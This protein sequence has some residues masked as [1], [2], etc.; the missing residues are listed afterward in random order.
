[1][2]ALAT[3][4]CL[5]CVFALTEPGDHPP[6][7]HDDDLRARVQALVQ[8]ILDKKQSVG[9]VVGVIEGGRRRV[10]GFGREALDGDKAPD[11]KTIF[12]IGSVTKVF[13]SLVLAQMD[14]EGLVRLDDPVERYLPAEVK[15]ASREGKEI[16]LENLA[17]HTSGLPRVP[18]KT[19]LLTIMS[20][21]PYASYKEKDLYDFLK[22]WK[23]APGSDSKWQYSNVGAGL[24][25]HALS[26]RAGIDY[27]KLIAS[28]ITEPLGMKD[29][30]VTLDTEQERRLAR[31]YQVGGHP[32]ARWTFDV[33]AGCGALH[34][35]ADDLLT[36]LSAE[37]GLE[38]TKLRTAMEA[39]QQPRR[40]TS[41]PGLRI[42]LAWLVKKLPEREGGTD[43][44]WHNGGTAGYSSFVGFI[45]AKK[46]AVVVLSNT[47]PSL[48]S[49]GVVDSVGVRVLPLLHAKEARPR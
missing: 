49:F 47:G 20:A 43:L 41:I 36:F 19:V 38:E 14:Q 26:R 40:E 44:V 10:F 35:T 27:S 13:T 37:M 48:G 11:G 22:G 23:P 34:S 2:T 17:T 45:K 6:A 9:M 31:P 3:A 30:R 29:T 39:T 15:I 8:P 42:G 32:A 4:F 7:D 16:T 5:S 18:L 21:A 25:G 12:E 28:R 33:L 24:L 1:M 46:T